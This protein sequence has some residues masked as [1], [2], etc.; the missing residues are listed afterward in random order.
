[1]RNAILVVLVILVAA[2][3][4][5]PPLFTHG[6]C[7]AEFD[8]VSELLQRAKPSLLTLPAA[9]N[10]LAAHG[11][12]YQVLSAQ[13]CESAPPADVV[14]CPGG[15]VLLGAVPVQN[16]ICRY[17]RDRAVRFQLGFNSLAQLV[18]IQTD[19]NPY[20]MLKLPGLGFEIDLSK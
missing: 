13:Q 5:V 7:T 4:W 6:A 16:Q 2:A 18:R 20:Q 9:E 8:A 1:M 14:A 19:M 17:Y 12:R 11:M 3:A 10:Y 15:V